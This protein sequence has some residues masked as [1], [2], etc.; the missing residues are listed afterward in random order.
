MRMRTPLMLAFRGAHEQKD[1]R[2]K[3]DLRDEGGERI[4]AGRRTLSRGAASEAAIRR[5]I[6]RDLEMLMNTINFESSFDLGDNDLVRRSILNYGL[7]DV[8]HRSIDEGG[9]NDIVDELEA[10]LIRYEP[11]LVRKSIK[12][13]RDH[14]VDA[15]N[16][17]VRFIIRADMLA[18]PLKVPVE[19]FADVQVD[20]GKVAISRL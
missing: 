8:T 2:V 14:S 15:A 7:P 19:F 13:S 4:I 10:A 17:L 5:E 1:A 3:A 18:D 11:R 12:V 16:L 20:T 9:V 6:S